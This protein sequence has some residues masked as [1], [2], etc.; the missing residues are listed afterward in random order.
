MPWTKKGGWFRSNKSGL[1]TSALPK[2][3]QAVLNELVAGSSILFQGLITASGE[4]ARSLE[5]W[6]FA[7]DRVVKTEEQQE[8]L[9]IDLADSMGRHLIPE[10]ENLQRR[11]ENLADTAVRITDTFRVTDNF[12]TLL[13]QSISAAFGEVG[14]ASGLMRSNLIDLMGGIQGASDAIAVYRQNFFSERERHTQNVQALVKNLAVLGV[15]DIPTSKAAYRQLVESQDLATAEGRRIA[16]GLIGLAPAFSSVAA[17]SANLA[18]A[19]P[20]VASAAPVGVVFNGGVSATDAKTANE[21]RVMH[22]D[23][24][25]GLAAIANNTSNTADTLDT[26]DGNGLPAEAA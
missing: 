7:V 10:L 21:A 20:V 17:T 2:D 19:A 13:G 9:A 5:D 22:Q 26:W 18:N 6:R 16:A 4:S 15:G 25:A 24:M 8:K 12:V 3:T 14:L 1:D 23:L 11:G